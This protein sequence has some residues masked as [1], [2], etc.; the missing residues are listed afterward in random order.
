ACGPAASRPDRLALFTSPTGSSVSAQGVLSAADRNGAGRDR[1][2]ERRHAQDSRRHSRPRDLDAARSIILARFPSEFLEGAVL[3]RTKTLL[4]RLILARALIVFAF[5][6]WIAVAL[7]ALGLEVRDVLIGSDD[8]VVQH[9][10]PMARAVASN[11]CVH[12][13]GDVAVEAL[14]V[15]DLETQMRLFPIGLLT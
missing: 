10:E 7:L 12:R 6:S 3:S 14:N 4:L 8:V 13:R 9:D 2:A 5:L 1:D 15:S 11:L